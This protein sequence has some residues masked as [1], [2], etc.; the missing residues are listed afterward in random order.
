MKKHLI[1]N[2]GSEI[3]IIESA[4]LIASMLNEHP[5][6]HIEVCVQAKYMEVAQLL[7]GVKVIHQLDLD[8][9]RQYYHGAIY[10][11]AFAMNEFST[12]LES[13][14]STDWDSIINYSNDSIAAYLVGGLKGENC[15]GT[16]VNSK[17]VAITSNKW[18]TYQN[19]VASGEYRNVIDRPTVR[20]HIVSTPLYRDLDRIRINQDY[21]LVANQNFNRIR[22]MKGS[23]STKVIAINLSAG[24]DQYCISR[25]VLE[26]TIEVL[27]EST[28]FKVVLLLNGENYQKN[29]VN[30]LNSRFNNSLISINVEPIALSAVLSN[31]DLLISTSNQQIAVADCLETRCVEIKEHSERNFRSNT[32]GESN[33]LIY[34]K[35]ESALSS[36][37][38]L[39]INEVFETEL[40]I[41]TLS[42]PNPT[43]KN[44]RDDYGSFQSQI[45]GDIDLTKE[46]NYHLGR[47]ISLENLGYSHNDQLIKH[48]K[49]N[50]DSDIL[51][52]F[53][54]ELREDLTGTVKLL[55][56]SLR[57]LKGLRNSET[58]LNSF[59]SYLD[60]LIKIG[61][62]D[63]IISG[64]VR[65]F[66]GRVENI[67]AEDTETNLK[68][69]ET[70]L[71]ELKADL[72]TVT[73]LIA[74]LANNN[75]K[76]ETEVSKSSNVQQTIG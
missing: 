18:A 38:L 42:S 40:P 31:V 25:A 29:I 39:A 27:E 28:D 41:S 52:K 47:C 5:T 53:T 9:V 62:K 43:Y 3:E 35:D 8:Q 12:A 45:R 2:L 61:Q 10:S 16:R 34:A 65:M 68:A 51:T 58:N 14:M 24:V 74:E 66:E 1:I 21:A 4:Y 20:N 72:Q 32:I 75:T 36:D 76:T 13:V 59:I 26:D 7:S 23:T 6:D 60:Q 30:E 22:Q 33:Y 50:V 64:I 57:A 37:I 49:S 67:E 54:S 70:A 71:F 55:L 69:I 56:S 44:V 17:G 15:F 19:Y 46:I 73:T 48:I 11:N 63:T